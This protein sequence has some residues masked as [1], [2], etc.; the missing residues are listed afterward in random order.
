MEEHVDEGARRG[1]ELTKIR[2]LLST[3]P[4]DKKH[5]NDIHTNETLL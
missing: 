4:L 5:S 3:T 1:E 2:P